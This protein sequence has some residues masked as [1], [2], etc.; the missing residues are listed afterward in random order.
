MQ[1]IAGYEPTTVL[2][3]AITSKLREVGAKDINVYTDETN[4]TVTVYASTQAGRRFGFRIRV[5]E[6]NVANENSEAVQS[7]IQQTGGT[8]SASGVVDSGVSSA[9]GDGNKDI[10]AVYDVL[11][12]IRDIINKL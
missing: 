1:T 10:A 2:A 9:G 11:V 4:D 3:N 5:V 12:E 7:V 8:K 6:A